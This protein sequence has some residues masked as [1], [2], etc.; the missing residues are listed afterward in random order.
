MELRSWTPALAKDQADLFNRSDLGW[1]ATITHGFPL[2]PQAVR[3]M[4]ARARSLGVWLADG[5]GGAGGDVPPPGGGGQ[6]G[7]LRLV[8]GR[9]SPRPW[10]GRRQGPGLPLPPGVPPP[11]LPAPRPPH[12]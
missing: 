5:G 8:P 7:R 9:R 11:R 4:E 10:H 1:P 6:R 2:T 3:T 12:L